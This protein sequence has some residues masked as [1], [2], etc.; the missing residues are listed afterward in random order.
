[1]YLAIARMQ[2]KKM[3]SRGPPMIPPFA[4]LHIEIKDIL[5]LLDGLG[6]TIFYDPEELQKNKFL[7]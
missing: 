7:L 3:I 4:F 5:E 2:R 6:A 1:M